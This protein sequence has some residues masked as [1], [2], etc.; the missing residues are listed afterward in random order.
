MRTRGHSSPVARRQEGS[1]HET[2]HSRI[3]LRR[4]TL[5]FVTAAPPV[6]AT[7]D[8]DDD[9]ELVNG[10]GAGSGEAAD[11]TDATDAVVARRRRSRDVAEALEEEIGSGDGENDDSEAS[12]IGA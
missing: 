11:A 9:G 3:R 7:A 5:A 8:D 2:P 4:D 6:A 1:G 10:S 12:G